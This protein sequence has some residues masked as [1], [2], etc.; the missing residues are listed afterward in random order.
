MTPTKRPAPLEDLGHVPWPEIKDST[1]C[2]AAIP[3]LLTAV[4]RGDAEAARSALGQ[5]RRRIC[6]YGFLVGQATAATVPFLWE[7]VRLPQV[8]CRVEILQLLKSIADA[9]QWETTAAAYPKLLRRR[10]NYVE[11]ER[12]ARH[13]VH[14]QRG[15]LRHLLDEPDRELVRASR[16]L[17]A[18]LTDR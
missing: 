17:A 9:R 1:G 2:A 11:W 3:F 7:L 15:V 5:L 8:T 16:E 14:A 6:Q 10:D 18:T 4:A 12:E 13:A